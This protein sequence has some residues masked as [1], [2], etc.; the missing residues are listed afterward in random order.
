M[1]KGI[2]TQHEISAP[3]DAVWDLIKTGANWEAWLPILTGSKVEGNLRTCDIPTPDGNTD[4]MEEL[5]LASHL[6]KTFLY[7][8]QKQQSF[9]ADDIVGYIRLVE[10]EGVTTMY[11]SVEMTIEDEAYFPELKA[12]IEHIYAEGAA[13][14]QTLAAVAV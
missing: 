13:K 12:Q 1:K 6:E 7:Q 11:W 9:P 3:I 2:Q 10:N 4:V 8:I 14:L 5:F